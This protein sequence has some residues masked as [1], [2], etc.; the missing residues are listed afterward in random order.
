MSKGIEGKRVQKDRIEYFVVACKYGP[1]K[2]GQQPQFM[3]LAADPEGN[4][5]QLRATE[6][7]VDPQAVEWAR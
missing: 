5:C 7:T 3:L 2:L 1:C 6:C 4:L